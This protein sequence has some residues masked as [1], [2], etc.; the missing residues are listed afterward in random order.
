MSTR[1]NI[2][3]K[4]DDTCTYLYHHCD[5]YPSGVGA[6]LERFFENNATVGMTPIGVYNSLVFLYGDEYELC[7]GIH[8][9][10]SYLY[11]ICLDDSFVILSC[12][13]SQR[14]LIYDVCYDLK[15]DTFAETYTK[16]DLK[17]MRV[18]FCCDFELPIG[19]SRL[20]EECPDEV[21]LD[22]NRLLKMLIDTFAFD[23]VRNTKIE[24]KK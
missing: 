23:I 11:E 18:R 9:D 16:G 24:I 14:N 15:V 20:Y 8:G 3:I 22:R 4:K 5:G 19:G 21:Q 13:N 10:I 6:E 1:C 7:D 17:D 12:R 2:V